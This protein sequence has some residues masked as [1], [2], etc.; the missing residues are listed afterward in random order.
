MRKAWWDE[1]GGGEKETKERTVG[2]KRM[3]NGKGGKRKKKGEETEWLQK[4]GDVEEGL[5]GNEMMRGSDEV[6]V[7]EENWDDFKAVKDNPSLL[8]VW[9]VFSYC[10][11]ENWPNTLWSFSWTDFSYP[12]EKNVVFK[13]I[14][15]TDFFYDSFG[16]FIDSLYN[17]I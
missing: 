17:E 11:V 3:K 7:L 1:G 4:G 2:D 8:I 6:K 12:Q 10:T 13:K 5:I 15:N 16:I 9:F 14:F